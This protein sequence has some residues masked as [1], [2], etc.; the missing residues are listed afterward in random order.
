MVQFSTDAPAAQVSRLALLAGE[1]N[2][3]FF[4][5]DRVMVLDDDYEKV[6]PSEL[7][8]YPKVSHR[9]LVCAANMCVSSTSRTREGIISVPDNSIQNVLIEPITVH[10]CNCSFYELGTWLTTD[11][12]PNPLSRTI[13]WWR[14][15]KLV[16]QPETSPEEEK[17]YPMVSG[18]RPG[19]KNQHP[20]LS[21]PSFGAKNQHSIL[22]GPSPGGKKKYAFDVV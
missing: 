18:P 10:S 16:P 3:Q 22:S 9:P 15:C 17:Q 12:K 4:D 8:T 19:V 20:M 14:R 5:A 6:L 13:Q 11:Y 1:T 2:S 21:V 7:A